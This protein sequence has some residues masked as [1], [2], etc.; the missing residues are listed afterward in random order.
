MNSVVIEPQVLR[1]LHRSE[2]RKRILMYLNEI[3]PSAT[4][5]SEIAR[6]IGSDPPSTSVGRWW[7]LGIG[8]TTKA[9]SFT[10]VLS[11]R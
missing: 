8:T 7:V 4:Y 6:V 10:W 2:L 3:Y 11:R 5:L 9:P 1:S